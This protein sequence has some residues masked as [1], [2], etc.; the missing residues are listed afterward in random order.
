MPQWPE[1]LEKN[2]RSQLKIGGLRKFVGIVAI[3]GIVGQV[4]RQ[5][6]KMGEI[7]LSK[8]QCFIAEG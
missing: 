8:I 3:I 2:S 4:G 1:P 6:N 5:P 7:S